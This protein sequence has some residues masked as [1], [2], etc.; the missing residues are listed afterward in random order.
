MKKLIGPLAAF[1]F[2]SS[3]AFGQI[4]EICNNGID[5]DGDGF[6]DCFDSDCVNFIGCAGGYVGNDAN[7]EAKPS[8]FPKFSMTLDWG[9]PNQV[10]DHLTRVTIGDLDRDAVPEVVTVN[11]VTNQLF[12]LDGR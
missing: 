3:F 4:A 10:A 8:S 2:L 11:S 5:D 12:I 7:C 1:V 9:S 6:I